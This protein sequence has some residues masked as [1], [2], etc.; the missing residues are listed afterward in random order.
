MF[1]GGTFCYQ[2][3]QILQEAG[4]R[5]YSNAPLDKKL[6]LSRPDQSRENTIVDMGDEFYM[7]GRPHPMIDGSQRAIRIVKEAKDPDV[8]ILFL[9]FILGYNSSM[10][11]VGELVDAIQEA[12]QIV[13][14][15]GNHLEVVASV[16]GTDGDSAG[17]GVAG[18]NVEGLWCKSIPE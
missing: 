12:Q 13:L 14:N 4:I 3:Q 6:G 9:D 5:V 18:Q 15:W 10:D 11:P 7:V 17:D 2:S 16:C 8:A 1:A